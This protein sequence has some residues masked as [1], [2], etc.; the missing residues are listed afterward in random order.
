MNRHATR[1]IPADAPA[2]DPYSGYRTW[3]AAYRNRSASLH[4]SLWERLSSNFDLI[5]EA[6]EPSWHGHTILVTWAPAVPTAQDWAQPWA[7]FT[8]HPVTLTWCHI[9][10]TCWA[11]LAL[12]H[13]IVPSET[14]PLV[15]WLPERPC[16]EIVAASTTLHTLAA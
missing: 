13:L 15:V 6:D 5:L 4:A 11:Q 7:I 1:H 14:P 12:G 16:A 9:L 3:R 2:P 8:Y 10:Q